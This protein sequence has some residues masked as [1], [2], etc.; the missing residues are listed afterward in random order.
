MICNLPKTA[1]RFGAKFWKNGNWQLHLHCN[2]YCSH[3]LS[4]MPGKSD[5]SLY[6]NGLEISK[7]TV[8]GWEIQLTISKTI[9]G[10]TALCI[11]GVKACI[12]LACLLQNFLPYSCSSMF[13][14]SL[15]LCSKSSSINWLPDCVKTFLRACSRCFCVII[16]MWRHYSEFWIQSPSD[17]DS[18][19]LMCFLPPHRTPGS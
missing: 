8:D 9:T 18:D 6:L 12:S 13:A 15:R 10:L 7:E 2:I 19:V 14:V 11:P 16:L 3:W 1:L 4:Q 17:L 5:V